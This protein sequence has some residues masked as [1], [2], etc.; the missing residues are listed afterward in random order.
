[1]KVAY[2]L[3]ILALTGAALY[4]TMSDSEANAVYG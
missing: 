3:G 1:M 4:F 2:L